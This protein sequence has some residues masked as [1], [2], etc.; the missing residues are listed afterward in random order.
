[1][2]LVL[3]TVPLFVRIPVSME[4]CNS[5]VL[6]NYPEAWQQAT[7]HG[8]IAVLTFVYAIC[9]SGAQFAAL[10][11]IH[12]K[13]AMQKTVVGLLKTVFLW[14]FFLGYQGHGHE[15]FSWIKLLG[16]ALLCSGTLLYIK[17]DS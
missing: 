11:V 13:N 6:E 12:M 16:M 9:V 4:V 7:Q 17:L 3:V 10:K 8:L 1:M 5:G 2:I 15:E 14:V